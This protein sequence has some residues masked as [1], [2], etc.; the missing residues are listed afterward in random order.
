M[1]PDRGDPWA[2]YDGLLWVFYDDNQAL[3]QRPR[4]LP[5]GMDSQPLFESWRNS[6]Q[7]FDE[8]MQ[9]YDGRV[10]RMPRPRR[11]RRRVRLG[12]RAG[13]EGIEPGASPSGER[14]KC[15]ASGHPRAVTARSQPFNGPGEVGAFRLGASPTR[16]NDIRL[17]SIKRFLGLEAK[18]VV[19]CELP[20]STHPDFRSLMYVGLSRARAHLVVIRPEDD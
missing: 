8:T 11:P 4:G 5:D 9:Y 3:Y 15:A 12:E 1:D 17:S 18:V 10:G 6:R 19:L 2:P 13:T 7:I 20:P 16:G 14:A